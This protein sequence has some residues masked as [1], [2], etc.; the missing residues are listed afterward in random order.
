MSGYNGDSGDDDDVRGD[1]GA[2]G[3]GLAEPLSRPCCRATARGPAVVV[4]RGTGPVL[5]LW[6]SASYCGCVEEGA[7]GGGTRPD[8]RGSVRQDSNRGTC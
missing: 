7:A 6:P 1:D 3:V 5:W 4:W 8:P 2:R